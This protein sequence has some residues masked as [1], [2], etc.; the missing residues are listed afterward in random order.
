MPSDSGNWEFKTN[1]LNIDINRLTDL[2]KITCLQLAQLTIENIDALD[3]ISM[4]LDNN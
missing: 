4:N 2:I 3:I 1:A